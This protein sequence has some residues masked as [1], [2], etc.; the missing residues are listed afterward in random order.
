M[1]NNLINAYET[2]GLKEKQRE[3]EHLRAVLGK[4]RGQNKEHKKGDH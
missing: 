1:I 4:I 3:M 2:D